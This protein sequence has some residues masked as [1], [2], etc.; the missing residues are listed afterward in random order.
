MI[1]STRRTALLLTVGWNMSEGSVELSGVEWNSTRLQF[2]TIHSSSS[3]L[4]IRVRVGMGRSD[5]V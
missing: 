2:V 5:E 4:G 1:T 3:T